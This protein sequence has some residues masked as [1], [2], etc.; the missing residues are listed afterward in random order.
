VSLIWLNLIGIKTF[1]LTFLSRLVHVSG[2]C[3]YQACACIRHVH[4]SGICMYQS[5]ACISHVH[6][7]VTCMYQSCACISHVH[8]SVMCMYQA[9]ACISHVHVS[10]MCMYQACA[11]YPQ[12]C[13]QLQAF[14]ATKL[15]DNA[16]AKQQ[17]LLKAVIIFVVCVLILIPY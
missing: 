5:R 11:L 1:F 9:C 15:I 2:M 12:P 14:T 16:E 4:V 7:S 17:S 3:M 6:V 10:G 8:V 13:K